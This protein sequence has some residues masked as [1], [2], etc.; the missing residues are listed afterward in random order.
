MK[1]K[2]L[3]LLVAAGLIFSLTACKDE[4]TEPTSNPGGQTDTK[5]D[6]TTDDGNCYEP[7]TPDGAPKYTADNC[8]GFPGAWQCGCLGKMADVAKFREL[9]GGDRGDRI[10]INFY[11]FTSETVKDLLPLFL[12]GNDAFT[13]KYFINVEMAANAQAH[14]LSVKNNIGKE[15]GPDIFVADVDYAMEFASLQGTATIS[16]LGISI[17]EGDFYQY[18]LDL[19]KKATTDGSITGLPHQA[20]P[21]GMLYRADIAR[22]VLGIKSEA[23]M[24]ALVKDWDGFLK[25]AAQI[26]EETE[27][28]M[29]YGSD[30]LKRNFLNTREQGWVVGNNF[31]VCEDTIDKFV[32]VTMAI[33]EMGGLGTNGTGQWSGPW[34]AGRDNKDAGVFSY[35]GSTWYLHHTHGAQV[36]PGTATWGQWGLVPGPAS[37]Y[38]GGTYWFGSKDAADDDDKADAVKQIIEFFCVNEDTIEIWVKKLGDFPA[39]KNVAKKFAEDATIKNEMFLF[40]TNHYA[41][42]AEIAEKINITKNITRY[43]AEMDTLFGEFIT[44]VFVNNMDVDEALAKLRG[45]VKGILGSN[46][47]V[48]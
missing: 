24:Q 20:T 46:I 30:E 3:A 5:V 32:E 8:P 13:D 16:E 6:P 2:L 19:M 37:F 22:D 12:T 29:I 4:P 1:K 21:G 28:K 41:V 7:Y 38:W 33:K 44:D 11:T 18:T 23:E 34:D 27:F 25:V 31:T 14:I 10:Q 42:F 9:Q 35:F 45:S 43:D 17:V 48:A 39:N 47:V 26:V 15:G 36:K 40:E